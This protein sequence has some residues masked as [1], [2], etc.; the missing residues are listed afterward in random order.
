MYCKKCNKEL[1]ENAKFCTACG[2]PVEAPMA[3]AAQ[4]QATVAQP[5]PAPAQP[6][7]A[8]QP[9]ATPAQ[10]QTAAPQPQAAPAPSY[11]PMPGVAPQVFNNFYAAPKAPVS[12]GGWIGRSLIPFIPFV[13]G[14]I[15]LIMLF[16]WAGD[17]TKEESFT[18]WAKAQLIVMLI[19]IVIVLFILLAFGFAVGNIID[20]LTEL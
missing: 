3:T 14:L 13:G 1:I 10:P 12:V 8:P 2:T 11:Q 9:Q 7:A 15:Y 18:N 16:I 6:Q 20:A 19:G 4:P 5:Q 17:K